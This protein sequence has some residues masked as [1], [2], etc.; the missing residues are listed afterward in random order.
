MPNALC[1]ASSLVSEAVSLFF[2]HRDICNLWNDLREKENSFDIS[3][4]SSSFQNSY[5]VLLFMG[6]KLE[7]I[8]Q[9]KFTF[10]N[11]I[12]LLF[13][14]TCFY[15]VSGKTFYLLKNIWSFKAEFSCRWLSAIHIDTS[16]HT[17]ALFAV[18]LKF[19]LHCF[20]LNVWFYKTYS[21]NALCEEISL[22]SDR[23]SI[24]Q[25]L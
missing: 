6:K 4:P 25:M 21:F 23:F 3:F 2:C 1:K 17:L 24:Y 22:S 20:I 18:R 10:P 5:T 12:Q 14:F 7:R 9:E 15:V 19:P 16:W 8:D 13:E 11:F